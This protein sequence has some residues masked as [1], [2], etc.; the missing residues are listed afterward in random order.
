MPDFR[1]VPNFAMPNASSANAKDVQLIT[2]LSEGENSGEQRGV[3][4][5]VSKKHQ[6]GIGGSVG[7]LIP[8]NLMV[9]SQ[10][11]GHPN[12]GQ[13]SGPGT[14]ISIQNFNTQLSAEFW[15]QT[16][17]TRTVTGQPTSTLTPTVENDLSTP[18]LLARLDSGQNEGMDFSGFIT[19]QWQRFGSETKDALK[20]GLTQFGKPFQTKQPTDT[21][22]SEST[23][24]KLKIDGNGQVVFGE[25]SHGGKKE[26]YR[27]SQLQFLMDLTQ[28]QLLKD[29]GMLHAARL[30]QAMGIVNPIRPLGF[31][32]E[33]FP[34][35][36]DPEQSLQEPIH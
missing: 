4:E 35:S 7:S 29:E 14:D 24:Q 34:P 15:R 20:Q 36:G 13:M 21:N 32:N 22:Q 8:T 10:G 26:P 19:S 11:N 3:N 25:K 6:G 18:T 23:G 17:D 27:K 33:F 30:Y 12:I 1:P 2:G 9:G 31:V 16:L 28:T 5:E